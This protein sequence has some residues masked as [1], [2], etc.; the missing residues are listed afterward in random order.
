[1]ASVKDLG[2]KI[3]ADGADFD[4]IVKLSAK[5]GIRNG[6]CERSWGEDLR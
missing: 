3:F 1:M 5:E 4:A 2:V 6:K